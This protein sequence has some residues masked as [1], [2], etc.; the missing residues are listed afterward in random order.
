MPRKNL[1]LK[2]E[3]IIEVP[4]ND[5]FKLLCHRVPV[6]FTEKESSN[7]IAWC[8][9]LNKKWAVDEIKSFDEIEE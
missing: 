6:G 4:T 5:S 3:K 1:Y 2:Q 7:I 9:I 8:T